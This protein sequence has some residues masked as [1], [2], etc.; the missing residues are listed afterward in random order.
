ML[1]ETQGAVR[2]MA[3]VELSWY[4]LSDQARSNGCSRIVLE[5][6]GILLDPLMG[7]L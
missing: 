6:N 1:C 2:L 5:G 7:Q 4:V 3:V